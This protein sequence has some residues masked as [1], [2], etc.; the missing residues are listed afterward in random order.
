MYRCHEKTTKLAQLFDITLKNLINLIQERRPWRSVYK[1]GGDRARQLQYRS[2]DFLRRHDSRNFAFERGRTAFA[3]GLHT[4]VTV[5]E[6]HE[7][8][9]QPNI[10]LS[11]L[12]S[13]YIE[14]NSDKRMSTFCN[15]RN[16]N[17]THFNI[18]MIIYH[19]KGLHRN[20]NKISSYRFFM[21]GS[22]C[23]LLMISLGFAGYI[24]VWSVTRMSWCEW[25]WYH[26]L[27][28]F[29]W[30][31]AILYHNIQVS[32]GFDALFVS[33]NN[34]I[35]LLIRTKFW[36]NDENLLVRI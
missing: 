24:S 31:L 15:G 28:C 8:S 18:Q 30:F 3:L 10:V 19:S 32:F 12:Q 25:Y 34:I 26:L 29:K 11:S 33:M 7:L 16:A 4:S 23:L 35:I 27:L 5:Y 13:N 9:R 17:S 36:Q 6:L 14:I 1:W 21:L 22:N 20:E 2:R